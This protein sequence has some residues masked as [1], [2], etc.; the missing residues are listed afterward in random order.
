MSADLVYLSWTAVLAVLL[1]VPYIAAGAA[2]FGFLTAEDYKIPPS[3]DLPEWVG[4]AHRAHLNLLENLP[5]F[6]ALVLVAHVS[7]AANSTTAMAAAV[8]FW[9]RIVQ[10]LVHYTGIPYLRTAAFA[11]GWFAQLS[12]GW[13]ILA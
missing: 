4:R 10:T 8:F 5:S 6:A 2:K 7:G 3:R 9:S 1:W 11:A 13:Q 12:I